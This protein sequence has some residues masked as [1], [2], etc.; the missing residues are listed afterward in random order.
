MKKYRI[1]ITWNSG[2]C[3]F[4]EVETKLLVSRFAQ[5]LREEYNVRNFHV[6]ERVNGKLEY[7]NDF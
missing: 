6:L 2:Y 1:C 4:V 3:E 5:A 7:C